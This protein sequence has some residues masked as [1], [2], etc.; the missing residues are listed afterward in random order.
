MKVVAF[1]GSPRKNGNTSALISYVFEELNKEDIETEIVQ[2]SG[3]KLGG[4]IACMNCFTNNNHHCAQDKD[5]LNEYDF[6]NLADI[7]KEQISLNI[8][9][10]PLCSNDC[11][12]LCQVCG[13]NLNS[14]KC[15]CKKEKWNNPF[16]KLENINL[17][18]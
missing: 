3:K 17:K 5:S 13:K 11:K 7:L 1:N 2:L 6:I 10:Q 9:I 14:E 8:P 12:G 16:S 4:C 15:K 18:K